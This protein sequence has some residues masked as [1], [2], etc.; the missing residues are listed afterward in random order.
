VQPNTHF[1]LL[2]KTGRRHTDARSQIA[3]LNGNCALSNISADGRLVALSS[4]ATTSSRPTRTGDRRVRSQRADQHGRRRYEYVPGLAEP[5]EC[6]DIFAHIDSA[7][8][9]KGPDRPKDNSN[10]RTGCG[11]RRRGAREAA[12]SGDR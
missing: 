5:G 6:A 8:G 3:R 1:Q 9:V 12:D 10:D 2:V 4:F 11:H 7:E